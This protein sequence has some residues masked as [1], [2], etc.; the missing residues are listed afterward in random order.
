MHIRFNRSLRGD[1]GRAKPGDVKLVS[2]EVGKSLI[3]RG[4]AVEVEAPADEPGG[5]GE[6]AETKGR[7]P[8]K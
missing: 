7:K 4:L 1:Y 6:D 5:D 8:A 2:K 3:A